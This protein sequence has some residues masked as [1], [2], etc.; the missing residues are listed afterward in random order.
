VNDTTFWSDRTTLQLNRGLSL[1]VWWG[2]KE[3]AW[4][5]S[6]VLAFW[7]N[8]DTTS[9]SSKNYTALRGGRERQSMG[10]NGTNLEK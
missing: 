4:R 7:W 10:R 3:G 8:R 6:R 5:E 2:P 1:E 9:S